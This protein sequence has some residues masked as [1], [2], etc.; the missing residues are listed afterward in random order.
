MTPNDRPINERV[1]VLETSVEDMRK[2]MTE[3]LKKEDRV[4]GLLNTICIEMATLQ[5]KVNT[6]I[7]ERAVWKNPLVWTNLISLGV[8]IT[9]LLKS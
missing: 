3:I 7:Q 4:T 8:A 9:V 6:V 5:Q 2:V 1:A